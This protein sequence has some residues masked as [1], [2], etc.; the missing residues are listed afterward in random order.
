MLQAERHK[1]I[2]SHVSK[3]GSALVRDLSQLCQVSQETIR[4]DLTALERKNRI[5]RS[6]GG[7]VAI[8]QEDI[9]TLNVMPS[10]VKLSQMVD[11]AE[12]FRKRTEEHPDAK[13]K[14][15]KAALKLIQPGDCIMLDNSSTCWFLARQIPDIDITV[16]TNSVK[17][18]QALACRDRVRVIGIGGEYSERHDDFHGPIAESIIRSFQIKTLF[19]SCQGFNIENGIR[20]GSE[21]NSKLKNIMLQVSENTVL[22]ADNSK[23]GK[24]AFSQVCTFDDINVLITNKLNDKEFNTQFPNL[25]IIECDK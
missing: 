2:C 9:P 15:S 13:M 17:I 10:S 20:D 1:L 12:S 5:I 19:L 14:I 21:I 24:Y 22:L 7:A 3:N 8:D 4:R 25:N 6:F 11:G 16:V 18:I 23:L